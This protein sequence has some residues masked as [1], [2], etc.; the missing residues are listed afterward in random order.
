MVF[1]LGGKVGEAIVTHPDISG[2][3]FTGSTTTGQRIQR[4]SAQHCK[5]LSLEVVCV[6]MY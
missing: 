5:K 3:T 4:N 2:V 6:L 1:G